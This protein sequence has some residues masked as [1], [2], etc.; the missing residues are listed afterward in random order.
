ML[1]RSLTNPLSLFLSRTYCVCKHHIF[2]CCAQMHEH[3]R[4]ATKIQAHATSHMP[5]LNTQR[6]H[7]HWIKRT[8]NFLFVSFCLTHR[9]ARTN[10]HTHTHAHTH[11]RTHAHTHTNTHT[12]TNHNTNIST[13]THA[14]KLANANTQTHTH[15]QTHTHKHTCVNMRVWERER[16][17]TSLY[18][19][20]FLSVIHSPSIWSFLYICIYSHRK[21]CIFTYVYIYVYM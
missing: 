8:F 6:V 21:I 3:A 7:T 10:A 20:L 12:H 4:S 14:H 13:Y 9:H 15:P 16:R 17:G 19:T 1:V 2:T 5:T 11:T 18:L